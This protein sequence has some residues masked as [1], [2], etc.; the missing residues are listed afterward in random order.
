M[1]YNGANEG[2]KQTLEIPP[3]IDRTDVLR[4]ADPRLHIKQTKDLILGSC[5]ESEALS[6]PFGMMLEAT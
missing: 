4:P 6:S 3:I 5:S 1:K 2:L